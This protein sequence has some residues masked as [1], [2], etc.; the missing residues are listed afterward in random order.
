MHPVGTS[1]ARYHLPVVGAR[2]RRAVV[3]AEGHPVTGMLREQVRE[4]RPEEPLVSPFVALYA[5]QQL[6]HLGASATRRAC[7]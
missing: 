4:G 1:S 7:S 2:D 5:F 3:S 6:S